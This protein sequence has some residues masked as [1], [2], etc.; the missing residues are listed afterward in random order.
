MVRQR[1]G[2]RQRTQSDLL[3]TRSEHTSGG[4]ARDVSLVVLRTLAGIVRFSA[5]D[6]TSCYREARLG[7]FWNHRNTLARSQAGGGSYGEEGE[8]HVEFVP[9]SGK[10]CADADY[11]ATSPAGFGDRREWVDSQARDTGTTIEQYYQQ[12]VQKAGEPEALNRQHRASRIAH[13]G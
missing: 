1:G 7:A 8:L 13:V 2:G 6:R 12:Q 9:C 10:Y 11:E 5:P 4:V 3:T